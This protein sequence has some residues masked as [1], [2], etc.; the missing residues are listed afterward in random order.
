ML[1]AASG[2]SRIGARHEPMSPPPA[3]G[4][5]SDVTAQLSDTAQDRG[6]S[7]MPRVTLQAGKKSGSDGS[8]SN[9]SGK[10]EEGSSAAAS[11]L[12]E[13][14]SSS[15][16]RNGVH[17]SVDNVETGSG[18]SDAS[19]GRLPATG[20]QAT[21]A[22]S[23]SSFAPAG[24][25]GAASAAKKAQ[26]PRG[27]PGSPERESLPGQAAGGGGSANGGGRG[28]A[29]ASKGGKGKGGKG[30]GKFRGKGRGGPA[31]HGCQT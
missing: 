11:A 12:C 13:R 25:A 24:K 8:G 21:S 5:L 20:G 30:K 6:P 9:S 2:M 22:K 19:W 4:G 7:G 28:S 31:V 27:T 23:G 1:T 26:Q 3:R 10:N 18:S 29:H 17:R 15:D 16:S 14:W